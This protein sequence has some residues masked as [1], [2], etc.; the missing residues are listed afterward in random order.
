MTALSDEE[1]KESAAADLASWPLVKAYAA[2]GA[3]QEVSEMENSLDHQEAL[4]LAAETA[5]A[6]G[7]FEAGINYRQQL[8]TISPED[9]T[10]HL[11]LIKL[12]AEGKKYDEAVNHL[13]QI[14][15][16]RTSSRRARWQ[17]VSL[18]SMIF[19]E[20]DDLW[21]KLKE[22][23]R[24]SGANDDEMLAAL[25]ALSLSNAGRT[26]EAVKLIIA[27]ETANPNPYLSFFVALLEKREQGADALSPFIRTLV[28][29]SDEEVNEAFWFEENPLR[30]II[31]LYA[32]KGEPR[33]ALL[34][35]ELEPTLKE[36]NHTERDEQVDP[37]GEDA[38]DVQV[39]LPESAAKNGTR[40]QTLRE[41]V[42][43]GERD[44]SV[45]LLGLLSR[46]AEQIEDFSRAVEFER[47]RLK[48]LPQGTERQATEA[49]I[50]QLL[51][52]RKDSS[53]RALVTYKVDQS[54]IASR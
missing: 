30:Q 23:V 40:Y 4:R 41:R 54:L 13:A 8:L 14:I 28:A 15:S 7:E 48:L 45:E 24:A 52:R 34:A 20:R 11:E 19:K 10:N 2:D 3:K 39:D 29:K 16:D 35:A 33:A 42:S 47:D 21:T 50:N 25:D 26:D 31:R 1:T 43:E 44:A 12:L 36:S 5:S 46:A 17:A 51:S 27:K 22:R 9:E 6:F 53:R 18:A 49:R 38:R 37:N 32:L